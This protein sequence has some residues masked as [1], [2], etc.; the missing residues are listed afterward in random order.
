[1][2]AAHFGVLKE[3]A[4]LQDAEAAARL[5]NANRLLEAA[6]GWSIP[7]TGTNAQAGYLR[8]PVVL[9]DR[10]ASVR[11]APE[12]RGLGIMPGYPIALPLLPGSP[13]PVVETPGA[14]VLAAR[15]ATLPVHSLLS[16]SDLTAIEQLLA[17][18]S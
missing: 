2:A 1:M 3:T 4:R 7:V 11:D 10:L 16:E 12:A 13:L 17:R 9:P 14:A 15:M 8:F 18:W 6:R 5:R